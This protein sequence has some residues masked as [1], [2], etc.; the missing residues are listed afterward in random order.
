MANRRLLFNAI[1]G[2]GLGHL[3]RLLEICKRCICLAPSIPPLFVT[4]AEERKWLELAQITHY[5]FP[6]EAIYRSAKII[7]SADISE[8]KHA[9]SAP[10]GLNAELLGCMIRWVRPVV[11]VL[12]T[13]YP[14]SILDSCANVGVPV[15]LIY[16]SADDLITHANCVRRICEMGGRILIGEEMTS[17]TKV[18]HECVKFVGSIYR[19]PTQDGRQRIAIRYPNESGT[20]RIVVTQGGGGYDDNNSQF[21]EEE[22]SFLSVVQNALLP[23]LD[24]EPRL[25]VIGVA[26]PFSTE[27]IASHRQWTVVKFEPDLLELLETADI[28]ITRSGYNAVQ[29]V[30]TTGC[31]AIVLPIREALEDQ[32]VHASR[33][34]DIGGAIVLPHADDPLRASLEELTRDDQARKKMRDALKSLHRSD[35]AHAAA[36]E[37]LYLAEGTCC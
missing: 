4:S 31:P 36:G 3:A 19:K 13:Y 11:A 9:S 8:D 18:P 25:R 27:H 5:F 26:G 32:A 35:G 37:I 12:D 24:V 23:L 16:S 6:S 34:V 10:D 1:N 15:V 7:D 17:D 29:D 2:I 22:P 14:D 20:L 30:V 21:Y 28:V 33:I